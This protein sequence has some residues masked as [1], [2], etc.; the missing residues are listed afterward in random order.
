MPRTS[1]PAYARVAATAPRRHQTASLSYR[2][3]SERHPKLSLNWM[4]S[5]SRQQTVENIHAIA[6]PLRM[7]LNESLPPVLDYVADQARI[8]DALAKI[9]ADIVNLE[10]QCRR[11]SGLRRVR[12][13]TRQKRERQ[14]AITCW[15]K[16][17]S[18]GFDWSSWLKPSITYVAMP[19]VTDQ[20]PNCQCGVSAYNAASDLFRD[21]SSAAL[22]IAP[23]EEPVPPG[24]QRPPPTARTRKYNSAEHS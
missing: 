10:E 24:L 14:S 21:A 16:C 5:L 12:S 1:R 15:F 8:D 2:R 22:P 7:M 3:K 19:F 18:C 6:P 11:A 4:F 23:G 17:S 9:N 20:C 13:A